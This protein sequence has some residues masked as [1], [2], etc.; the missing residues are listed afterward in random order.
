MTIKVPV[1]KESVH[2]FLKALPDTKEYRKPSTQGRSKEPLPRFHHPIKKTKRTLF[3]LYHD[4]KSR[5]Y[6]KRKRTHLLT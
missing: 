6:S 1:R 4:N 2:W 3:N 5:L